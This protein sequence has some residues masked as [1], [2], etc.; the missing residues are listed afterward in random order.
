V[1]PSSQRFKE[2]IEPMDQS[3]RSHTRAQTGELSL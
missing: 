1:A 2:E 3:K